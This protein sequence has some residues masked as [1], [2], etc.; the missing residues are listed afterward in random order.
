MSYT[1]IKTQVWN[2]KML[3]DSGQ[4]ERIAPKSFYGTSENAVKT[5]IWIDVSVYV[6]IAIIK[7][8]L[9]LELSFCT[10]L[11]IFNVT[12]FEQL[13][14]IQMLT[15]FSFKNQTIAS[16]NHLLLFEL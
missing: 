7:K 11:Q 14:I 12:A 2:L 1:R 16:C 5:Q 13:S 9:N 8:F 6:L 4:P 15:S 3:P 10:I